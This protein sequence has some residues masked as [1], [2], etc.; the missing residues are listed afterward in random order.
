MLANCAALPPTYELPNAKYSI[1]PVNSWLGTPAKLF[2]NT[3]NSYELKNDEV[4]E[5][6]ALAVNTP[7]R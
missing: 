7:F 6:I 1:P 5:Y 2:A 4:E 3:V